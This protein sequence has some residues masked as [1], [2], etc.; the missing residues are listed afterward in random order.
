MCPPL[1]RPRF[2]SGKLLT[3]ED[4]ALEQ[5]YFNEKVKRHN[6]S[7]HG[8]GIINGLKVTT[9]SGDILVAPGMAL[10]CEG[11]E[12]VIETP[13][14]I[15]LPAI[16]GKVCYVN[17]KF[18]EEP[19]PSGLQEALSLREGVEVLVV[20]ENCN[21]GHRHLHARWLSCGRPHALTIARLKPGS[22]GWHVDRR[23]RAP[24]IR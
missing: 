18:S 1:E 19:L 12:I 22:L 6:R 23:Y 24:G 10:D 8:F 21:A 4:L 9:G 7:L 13:L 17:L 16:T 3:P 2:F 15:T 14:T 20:G 11:N 5:E